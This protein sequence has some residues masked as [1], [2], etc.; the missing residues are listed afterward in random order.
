VKNLSR[1]L[2][3]LFLLSRPV[4]L[5]GDEWFV[6]VTRE[7]GIA[8]ESV[9]G[10]TGKRYL[11]ETMLAGAA[12][13]DY[14]GDGFLDLYLV[15][16]NRHPETALDGAAGSGV[17]RDSPRDVL[18]RN[19]GGKRFEDVTERAGVGDCGY[20]MGAAVGDFDGDGRPDLYV[21]N[22]GRNTLYRN[23]GDG[24]FEDA[25]DRA[26]VGARTW[27][28]S[29]TWADF[30][31]DGRLDLFVATYLDYDTR[32]HGACEALVRGEKVPSYCHPHRFE[33]LPDI[34]FRNQGDGTFRDVSRESG[35][36]RSRGWLA[37]K[38]LGVVASDFDRDGDADILVANDSVPNTLWRNEGGMRFEDVGL[39]T[40]FALGAEGTPRAGMGI[41]RGD[42]DGDGFI[43]VYVTNFS[44]ETD[45]LYINQEGQ[46][47]D[48]TVERG[49]ARATYLPLAFGTR[50]LDFDLDGDVDLYVANGHILDNA[51][52]LHPGEGITHGQKDFLFENDGRG[53]FRD[54]SEG[55]GGWFGRALAGR[56]V[57]EADYDNDGDPDLLVTHSGGRA[58]LLENRAPH[59]GGWIGLDLRAGPGRGTFHGARVELTGKKESRV[60]EVQT[61]GSY[62]SAHDPRV[63]FALPPGA[64][65]ATLRIHWPGTP[66][67]DVRS[68]LA[69]GRYHRIER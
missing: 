53:Y 61:D 31:G 36:A 46:F 29:A 16:G 34:L 26:G 18:Y 60:H 12:W 38:G 4:N 54:A 49:L 6:D 51:E 7:R 56:A 50:F 5:Q 39:E 65:A 47:A 17:R 58:I 23:R 3:V 59:G 44:R 27:S 45:T 19:V 64:G 69:L 28:T 62:L 41:D 22:Y 63:R 24:T 20:G 52:Q 67:P 42:V 57:A 43:D 9:S 14:D 68:A 13:I 30:D 48:A 1:R 15:Q 40:G 55:A 2:G 37:G 10:A 66:Q 11:V 21:T 33:G 25:T 8:F 35:I 32:R